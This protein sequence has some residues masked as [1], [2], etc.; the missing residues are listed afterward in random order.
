HYTHIPDKDG[1]PIAETLE[2][3]DAM[4]SA[5]KIRYI[6]VSNETP[7]GLLEYLRVAERNTLAR[8]VSVQNPYNLLNRLFE[9]GMS[10]IALRENVGL[11]AYSPLAFGVLT[12]KYINNQRPENARLSLYDTYK[13]YLNSNGIKMTEK[14]VG[15]AR[16]HGLDPAQ[17]ALAFIL[18]RPFLT[19]AI[20]GA[21][22]LAQL[23]S[24]I[25]SIDVQLPDEI[26]KKI[27]SLNFEQPSPCP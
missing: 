10:E 9:I 27:D 26:L 21:T 8:I 22:S 4:V 23:R 5:G 11:L 17:M 7:W 19:S 16:E 24:N 3:L 18:S 2:A 6:G 25:A 15:L 13:R 14:Y 1:T 12:G 20:I